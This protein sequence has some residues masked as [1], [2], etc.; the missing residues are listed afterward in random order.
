MGNH[1]LVFGAS[2]IQ[3]WAVVN[4]ILKGY[5]SEDAFD[6]VTALANR[7]M[8]EKMLWPE[9]EKLQ[10]ISGIDLLTDKGQRGLETELGQRVPGNRE[11]HSSF[12][13]W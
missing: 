8:I 7:P 11:R 13:L 5:P 1:A 4:E 3:G 2:G 10:A 9:S 6:R 12:L